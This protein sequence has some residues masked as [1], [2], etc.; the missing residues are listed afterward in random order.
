MS[1]NLVDRSCTLGGKTLLNEASKL[2]QQ[3]NLSLGNRKRIRF[4]TMCLNYSRYPDNPRVTLSLERIME[5]FASYESARV[6]I[7]KLNL[8][9]GHFGL[10]NFKNYVAFTVPSIYGAETATFIRELSND[11]A[12]KVG[13]PGYGGPGSCVLSLLIDEF[14]GRHCALWI[15]AIMVV[16]WKH[17]PSEASKLEDQLALDKLYIEAMA[18]RG[19][20]S[21]SRKVLRL[22]PNSPSVVTTTAMGAVDKIIQE[23][24]HCLGDL[25]FLDDN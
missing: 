21:R 20:V 12:D 10:D 5:L 2:A 16:P 8:L 9:G 15:N 13:A 6:F 14:R 25:D 17:E 7:D 1:I 4:D 11:A 24:P 3:R 19:R 18:L 22:D 23:D